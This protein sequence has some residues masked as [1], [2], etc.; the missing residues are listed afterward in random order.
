VW[1][2]KFV[3]TL[4]DLNGTALV[5]LPTGWSFVGSVPLRV[6]GF[7]GGNDGKLLPFAISSDIFLC[8]SFVRGDTPDSMRRWF[9]VSKSEAP[10]TNVVICGSSDVREL[11]VAVVTFGG[12]LGVFVGKFGVDNFGGIVGGFV[13]KFGVDNLVGIVG[14]VTS[15]I[16]TVDVGN[17]VGIVVGLVVRTKNIWIIICF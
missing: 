3:F 15:F 7:S 14:I 11:G 12:I 10:L 1:S 17:W 13:G 5:G 9:Q 4:T 8:W 16:V 2:S 6:G